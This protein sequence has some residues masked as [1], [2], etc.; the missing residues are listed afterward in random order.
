MDVKTHTKMRV[1]RLKQVQDRI[2][3]SRSTIYDRLNVGSPRYDS[4]F[5]RPLKIGRSAVGWLEESVDDWIR[6]KMALEII[7]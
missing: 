6:S 4:T 1:L 5:P 2:G 3:L 7:E